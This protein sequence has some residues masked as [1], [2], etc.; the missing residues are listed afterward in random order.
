MY[1]QLCWF[2]HVSRMPHKRLVKQVLLAKPTGKQPRGRPRPRWNCFFFAETF[3]SFLSETFWS[4]RHSSRL[5]P[6]C[7]KTR[8]KCSLAYIFRHS[9]RNDLIFFSHFK[10]FSVYNQKSQWCGVTTSEILL[11]PVL[12]WSQQNYLQLLLTMRYSKSS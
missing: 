5:C 1:Q 3:Q 8:R 2:G 7:I 12:V 11:G 9:D 6:G 10:K 4:P